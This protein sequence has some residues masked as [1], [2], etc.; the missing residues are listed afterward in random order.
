MKV[1]EYEI[2][3]PEAHY[4]GSLHASSLIGQSTDKKK[5]TN[6]M[7]DGQEIKEKVNKSKMVKPQ[8]CVNPRE[9]RM[10]LEALPA[11]VG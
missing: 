10:E 5:E 9:L 6:R 8:N 4:P 3:A 11:D 7:P 1:N 2:K